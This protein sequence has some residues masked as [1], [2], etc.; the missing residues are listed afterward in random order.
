M[1]CTAHYDQPPQ[2][3]TDTPFGH[4]NVT[5]KVLKVEN[6]RKSFCPLKRSVPC[7]VLT[8]KSKRTLQSLALKLSVCSCQV[9]VGRDK[10]DV[11]LLTEG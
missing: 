2:M 1:T 6:L 7:H 8:L 9:S 10:S 4:F 11:S 3:A 5:Y